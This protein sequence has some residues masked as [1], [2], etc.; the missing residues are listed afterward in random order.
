MKIII[1]S[2]RTIPKKLSLLPIFQMLDTAKTPEPP[3]D[4]NCHPSA[5][6]FT[7]LHTAGKQ[8]EVLVL[9]RCSYNH[10]NSTMT[11]GVSKKQIPS[12]LGHNHTLLQIH[13]DTEMMLFTAVLV[14]IVNKLEIIQMSTKRGIIK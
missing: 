2:L 11:S 3:V 4:H 5:K 7:F 9:Q 14:T 13:E 8:N 10:Q 6:S 1:L 12:F